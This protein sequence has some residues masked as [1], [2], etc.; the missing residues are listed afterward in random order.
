MMA[1]SV[2]EKCAGRRFR[3]GAELLL[4]AAWTDWPDSMPCSEKISFFRHPCEAVK[5][6]TRAIRLE[7]M[8]VSSPEIWVCW[9]EGSEVL[10]AM[11]PE[12]A[13]GRLDAGVVAE[14]EQILAGKFTFTWKQGKCGHCHRMALSREGELKDARPGAKLTQGDL[15]SPASLP[16]DVTVFKRE[17]GLT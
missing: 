16:I 2:V 10:E 1:L 15:G 14:Y 13:Q 9:D 4:A 6:R 12:T 5:G 3:E 17:V 11:A 7:D 8:V